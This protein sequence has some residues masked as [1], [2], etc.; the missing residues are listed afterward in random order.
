MF[1]L[2]DTVPPTLLS[3][4]AFLSE[5]PPVPTHPRSI[6]YPASH[7]LHPFG[8]SHSYCQHSYQ[9]VPSFNLFSPLWPVP[10][11]P[12]VPNLVAKPWHSESSS[13]V[14][15]N[16]GV[17]SWLH[18]QQIPG[19]FFCCLPVVCSVQFF[20]FLRV[21]CKLCK[22]IFPEPKSQCQEAERHLMVLAIARRILETD[23]CNA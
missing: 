7:L 20:V 23:T 16:K 14:S 21:P 12:D 18:S 19:S 2:S 8:L 1:V 22:G 17:S 3:H 5:L 4:P 15:S 13:S 11:S 9:S 6:C 10:L